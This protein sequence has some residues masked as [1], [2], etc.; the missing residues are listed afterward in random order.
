[1]T[2]DSLQDAATSLQDGTPSDVP[3]RILVVDDDEDARRALVSGLRSLGYEGRSAADGLE[4]WEMHEREPADVIL[5]DWRMPR[6]DGVELCRRTRESGRDSTYFMFVTSYSDREHL[7]AGLEAGADAYQTK[8]V[9]LDELATRLGVARR[10]ISAHRRL[11]AEN[12]A[13][14]VDSQRAHADARVDALTQVPNRLSLEEALRLSWSHAKRYGH[15]Y[16]VA[17]CDIDNFKAFN[18]RHGHLA[19]DEV[20][21]QVAGTIRYTLRDGDSLYRYGGEEFV[22]VLPEQLLADAVVAVE[23]I[24]SAV[25]GLEVT[26]VGGAITISFG[27]AEL[28]PAQDDSPEDCLRR[29]DAALYRAKAEGRNRVATDRPPGPPRT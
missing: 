14:R 7:L 27:V 5:A 2:K 3:L 11:L 9:D 12:A 22:V 8:P 6:M 18:D 17:I 4:A 13:L 16:S 10:A 25:E 19:G 26:G 20:L 15:R 28:D 23:R 1:M 29:A 21:R 24:R